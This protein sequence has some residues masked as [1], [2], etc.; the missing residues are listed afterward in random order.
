[1]N[2][3]LRQGYCSKCDL[4]LVWKYK[5][6]GKV[7][8]FIC[9]YCNSK[10]RLTTYYLVK[11]PTLKLLKPIKVHDSVYKCPHDISD[12]PNEIKNCDFECGYDGI[13]GHQQVHKGINK[14]SPYYDNHIYQTRC[15]Y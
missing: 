14:D 10:V 5:D 12:N 8:N 6:F 15:I 1:M 3:S 4:R 13:I 2:S 11:S 9:P 7:S